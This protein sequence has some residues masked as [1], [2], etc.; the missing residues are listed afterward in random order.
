MVSKTKQLYTIINCYK[1]NHKKDKLKFS[2][3]AHKHKI[4]QSK[5]HPTA[6]ERRRGRKGRREKEEKQQRQEREA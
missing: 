4:K 3:R 1:F 6:K 2:E 5:H